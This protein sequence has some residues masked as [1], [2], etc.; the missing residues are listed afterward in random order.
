MMKAA[1]FIAG[2]IAVVLPFYLFQDPF[3]LWPSVYAASYGGSAYLLAFLYYVVTTKVKT[4]LKIITGALI[5]V[6]IATNF[7][8]ISTQEN[9]S[10]YQ[11]SL[12]TKIRVA[13]G[14]GIL[15]SEDV[16]ERALPVYG[17]YKDQKG[18]KKGVGTVFR[19]LHKDKIHD[20]IFVST[21]TEYD[22]SKRYVHFY[23]DTAVTLISVDT[24]A[25]GTNGAFVN[26]NGSTGKLQSTTTITAR[27]VTYERNN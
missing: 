3:D 8:F 4:R 22:A 12:L 5:V 15:L 20:D 26:V 13:I 17:A 2:C 27:G 6:F 18:K 19:E 23:S 1:W 14:E 24:V 21:S 16:T 9:M 11:R 7:L 10:R 25:R